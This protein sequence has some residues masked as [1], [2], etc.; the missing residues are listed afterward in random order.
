MKI[1]ICLSKYVINNKCITC[2]KDNRNK[3]GEQLTW[4]CLRNSVSL[5]LY[6]WRCVNKK[7]FNLS[8]IYF[9]KKSWLSFFTIK[10]FRFSTFDWLSPADSLLFV[11]YQF[12]WGSLF[13]VNHKIKRSRSFNLNKF[14]LSYVQTLTNSNIDENV[15]FF[16]TTKIGTHE[17]KRIYSIL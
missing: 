7:L 16:Q 3:S 12:L 10:W 17:N 2:I 11:G 13:Q 9:L 15:S 5:L 4:L 14:P 8:A 1:R 6:I